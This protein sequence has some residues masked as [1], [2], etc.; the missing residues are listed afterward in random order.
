MRVSEYFNLGKTQPYLDFVDVRLDTDIAVFIDPTALMS[1]KSTWGHECAS[2]VKIYFEV[3]L[4]RIKTEQH[5]DA[6]KLVSSLN[7][8]NE[9]HLGYSTGRSRGHAFGAKSATSVW[10]ALSKSQASTSGLLRDL[11]DTCLL[12]EGIGPDMISD[13]VCNI[14]RGPLIRYTQDMCQYYDI[15]L[16]SGIDSGPIWNPVFET[17][18]S[19]F[20]SLPMTKEGKVILVPK[21]LVRQNLSYRFD[22]YYRHYLLPQMQYE[23]LHS[24]SALVEFLKDGT[25]RVTKTA[26]IKKYGS[27]KLAVVKET[28][29]RPHVLEMYKQDRAQKPSIP[30]EHDQLSEIAGSE[31][32]DWEQLIQELKT[33]PT[34]K[35]DAT[36]YEVIIEKILSAMFY[37]SLCKPL[38]Q[39]NIH[40]GR[41]RIDITYTNEARSGFFHWLAL[42]YPSAFVFVEC[43]NYGKEIGNPEL[44]QLSGRF[45]PSRGQVGILVCR[46]VADTDR[47]TRGCIDTAKD[48]RGFILVLTD[49]DIEA[50][51]SEVKNPANHTHAY[52]L[53][54]AKFMKLVT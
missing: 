21:V 33:L 8:R 53:L 1:L 32:P 48:H 42:H 6:R 43:K 38:K 5:G 28:L 10:N 35:D 44:D 34:G 4:D 17:W 46:S 29:K 26:L 19:D 45:S 11:E 50:L 9:F 51:V 18:Q 41:K 16:T 37:P 15:P 49:S 52:S 36:A 20:V 22:K 3:V 2:L 54:K 14:L 40:E 7:E 30:L 39:H 31:P 24:S 25:P 23:E 12:I 13:A 47:V 27:D